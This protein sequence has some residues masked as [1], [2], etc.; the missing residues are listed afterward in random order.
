MPVDPHEEVLSA[1]CDG[2]L[3]ADEKAS[4]EQRLT[5]DPAYRQLYEELRAQRSALRSLP[6]L[7]APQELA[8][9]VSQRINQQAPAARVPAASTEKPATG[10]PAPVGAAS[11]NA[12]TA[13]SDRPY[14]LPSSLQR[15]SSEQRRRV[16]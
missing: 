10:M 2:E 13:L 5:G 11:T 1:Y 6:R 3:S 14:S 8:G 9:L 15:D 4:V 12:P 7:R 16:T